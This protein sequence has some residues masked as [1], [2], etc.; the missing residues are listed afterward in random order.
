MMGLALL[1]PRMVS[2]IAVTLCLV[3]LSDIE[4]TY[5]SIYMQMKRDLYEVEVKLTKKLKPGE[6]LPKEFIA[7]DVEEGETRIRVI[8][9]KWENEISYENSHYKAGY[10][11]DNLFFQTIKKHCKPFTGFCL[12]STLLIVAHRNVISI[13]SLLSNSWVRHLFYSS[14]IVELF[15][16]HGEVAVTAFFKDQTVRVIKQ[17]KLANTGEDQ[18]PWEEQKERELIIKEKIV[19]SA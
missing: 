16:N 2:P 11:M 1:Y 5:D 9:L 15:R 14:E 6:E 7:K 18:E 19:D 4:I 10:S 12:V 8:D 17:K 3:K 13:Y